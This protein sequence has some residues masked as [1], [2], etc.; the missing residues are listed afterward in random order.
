MHGNAVIEPGAKVTGDV[1]AVLGEPPRPERRAG[2]RRLNGGR[3]KGA[4]SVRRDHQRRCHISGRSRVGRPYRVLAAS[5][6][7]WVGRVHRLA[8]CTHATICGDRGVIWSSRTTISVCRNIF[9]LQWRCIF[10][11]GRCFRDRPA[12]GCDHARLSDQTGSAG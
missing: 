7:R 5:A 12:Q 8:N 6:P 3:R 2:P 11:M 10:P 9:E 1:T 4:E